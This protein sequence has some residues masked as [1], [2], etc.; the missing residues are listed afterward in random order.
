MLTLPFIGVGQR[1]RTAVSLFYNAKIKRPTIMAKELNSNKKTMSS[2]EIAELA[3]KQHNDVLKA[4][5]AMEPAWEKVTEGKFS[6]SEYKDSTG[7]TLPCYELNY[8][9]CM[10]IASK[11]NDET[12]AKLVLRWDALETGKAEPIITSVKTEVKQ[13]TISDKMKAATWAAKFLN[14][15]ESSKLIIA[16]QILEPYNLPLPDYTPSKGVL[17]S[18]SK[19]LAEMG[20]KKQ[21]SA[22]VF[23]KRAIEK[24]YLY[25]IERDSSHG[26]KKQFKSITEKGLSYG[27]NQVSPN[28]PRETQP[29][30]YADKF[31]ELL[32]ILGFQFMGGLP[33][34]N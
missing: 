19:L 10:Y 5:R 8:Q 20:L 27:E 15:N 22:Q 21:I 18:A 12:R 17:K 29:L 30:W 24:G 16:K 11:F 28:N 25:D 13:P 1:E 6:L 14:L 2:L 31:S 32:G 4:I 34:E 3:G 23:N 33:Y 7:R 26:Q 9:E